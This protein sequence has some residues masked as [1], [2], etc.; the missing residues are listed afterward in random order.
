[1]KLEN[2]LKPLIITVISIKSTGTGSFSDLYDPEA[3]I[4]SLLLVVIYTSVLVNGTLD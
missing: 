2:Q 1:M 3:R 4:I